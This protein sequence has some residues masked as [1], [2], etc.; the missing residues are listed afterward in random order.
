MRKKR[1]LG[2]AGV[3]VIAGASL[4]APSGVA[5]ASGDWHGCPSGDGCM[6]NSAKALSE[7]VP[8]WKEYVYSCYNLSYQSGTQWVYN[9]QTSY[10]TMTLWTQ[11]GCNGT[12]IIIPAGTGH[13]EDLGPIWS[14][15]LDVPIAPP[16]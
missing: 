9:N 3:A 10:A 2:L 15:S 7:Q 4:L 11:A 12:P 8:T 1:W 5:H 14:I 16:P 13:Y 6:Y